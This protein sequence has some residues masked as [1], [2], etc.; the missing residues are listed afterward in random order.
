MLSL[1]LLSLLQ[2]VFAPAHSATVVDATTNQPL[3]GVSVR[4]PEPGVTATS[5]DTQRH[6]QHSWLAP[7]AGTGTAGLRALARRRAR[8]AHW[9]SQHATPVTAGLR[10]GR[11]GR[12]LA[13]TVAFVLAGDRRWASGSALVRSWLCC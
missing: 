11:S 6:F 1:L 5:T 8:R 12:F 3:A 4:S 2:T 13:S 9:G 10:P 7:L